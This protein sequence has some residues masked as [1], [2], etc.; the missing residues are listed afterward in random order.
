MNSKR[1]LGSLP[2]PV[3]DQLGFYMRTDVH[4]LSPQVHCSVV[5]ES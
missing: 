2:V 3:S 5:E 4:A 1:A